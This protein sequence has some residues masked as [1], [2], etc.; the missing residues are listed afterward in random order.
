MQEKTK[1]I[2]TFLAEGVRLNIVKFSDYRPF[3][4]YKVIKNRRI[5]YTTLTEEQARKFFAT[6]V[7]NIVLQTKIF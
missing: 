4:R 2:C 3:D 6:C 7:N 5:L 1:N